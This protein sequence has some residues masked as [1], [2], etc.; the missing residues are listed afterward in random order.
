MTN[1]IVASPMCFYHLPGGMILFSE[2]VDT[3]GKE[4]T[5]DLTHTAVVQF[6]M[7]PNGQSGIQ[8]IKA[9]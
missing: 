6:V 1:A 5:F 4:V 8:A 7:G 3:S 2:G 9:S